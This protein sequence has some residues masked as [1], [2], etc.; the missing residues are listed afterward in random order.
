MYFE[1]CKT[2]IGQPTHIRKV[3]K[4]FN[5]HNSKFV[6]TSVEAKTKLVRESDNDELLHQDMYQSAVGCLIYV[7]MK[8]R[9]DIAYAVGKV[10][11]H[12]SKPTFQHW[13]AIKRILR[14]LNGTIYHGLLLSDTSCLIG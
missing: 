4:K 2:W 3:L 14:Y 7:S 1:P 10:A 12:T 9:P 8:I 13:N 5:M 11:R 6:A